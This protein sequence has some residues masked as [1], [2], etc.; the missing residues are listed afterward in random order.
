MM[1]ALQ[2]LLAIG[3]T[4]FATAKGV[5]VSRTEL[6][7]IEVQLGK[8]IA[9]V[10]GAKVLPLKIARGEAPAT[11]KEMI[12]TLKKAF[13]QAR[14]TFKII[15]PKRKVDPVSFRLDDASKSDASLLIQWGFLPPTGSL[16]YGPA[17]TLGVSEFGDMLGYFLCRLS[18]LTQIANSRF[19]PQFMGPATEDSV[20]RPKSK[21]GK[22]SS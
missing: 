1:R 14:P 3:L 12:I 7:M 6:A 18:E 10:T 16:L 21:K 4:S 11:R 5:P 22:S 13:D 2:I 9:D 19:S 17:D 8:V 20:G 15:P